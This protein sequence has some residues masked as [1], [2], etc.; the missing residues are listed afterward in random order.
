MSDLLLDVRGLRAGYDRAV[1]IHAKKDD[2]RG[3]AGAPI[4]CGV[5]EQEGENGDNQQQATASP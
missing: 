2:A 1:V 5:I 4:A 3:N